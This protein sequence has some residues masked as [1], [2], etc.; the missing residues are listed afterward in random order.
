MTLVRLDDPTAIRVSRLLG[1]FHYW[2][3]K[4]QGRAMPARG[5]IDPIVMWQWLGNLLLIDLPPDPMQYRVRLDGVNLVQFYNHSRDGKGV[6]VIPKE[7]E[8]RNVMTHY[9]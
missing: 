3:G 2:H 4:C 7:E 9:L 5:D 1:L 6:E 8:R